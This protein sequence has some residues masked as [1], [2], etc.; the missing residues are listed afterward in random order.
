MIFSDTRSLAAPVVEGC[1]VGLNGL[2]MAHGQT[3]SG[4]SHTMGIL[5]G[6]DISEVDP[7][8]SIAQEPSLLQGT[9][10]NTTDRERAGADLDTGCTARGYRKP[11]SVQY[12]SHNQVDPGVIPR[13]L[14]RVFDHES[15]SVDASVKVKVSLLQIYNETVQVRAG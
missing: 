11:S 13:A 4:K 9:Q 5:R 3:A 10:R 1:L 6:I 7:G 14:S 8:P 12:Y 15:R 2:I